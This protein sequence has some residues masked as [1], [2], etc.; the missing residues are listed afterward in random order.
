[1]VLCLYACVTLP[2]EKAASL[3]IYYLRADI[4]LGLVSPKK[5]QWTFG[6]SHSCAVSP[7]TSCH[8]FAVCF[9]NIKCLPVLFHQ[10]PNDTKVKMMWRFWLLKVFPK[11]ILLYTGPPA[12]FIKN[13]FVDF[14]TIQ[15]GDSYIKIKKISHCLICLQS[16]PKCWKNQ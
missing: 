9:Q 12:P 6:A 2:V 8:V 15:P 7:I 10:S 5:C 13:V 1:M 4:S 14:R 16:L 11:T 3:V